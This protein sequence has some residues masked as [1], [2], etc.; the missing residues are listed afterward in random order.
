LLFYYA[1][2][3]AKWLFTDAAQT[4][5][6]NIAYTHKNSVE[7]KVLKADLQE[8]KINS[9]YLNIKGAGLAQAV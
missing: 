1:A 4:K 9:R 5:K 6:Y 2:S 7:D 3:T 8:K